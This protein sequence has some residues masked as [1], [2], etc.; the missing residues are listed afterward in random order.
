MSTKETDES[1]PT[2]RLSGVTNPRIIEAIAAQRTLANQMKRILSNAPKILVTFNVTG[3][4][5]IGAG[6]TAYIM[7]LITLGSGVEQPDPTT[8]KV[9]APGELMFQFD[10][11]VNDAPGDFVPLTVAF[12]VNPAYL[13]AARHTPPD[14]NFPPESVQ[15]FVE[16]QYFTDLVQGNHDK[17]DFKIVIMQL[18]TRILGIIDPCI[19]HEN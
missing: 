11:V 13:P 5:P 6:N 19:L 12:A 10:I 3:F 4:L 14:V 8:L 9:V 7:K 16:H 18:S 15:R 2:R 17:Y 1:A